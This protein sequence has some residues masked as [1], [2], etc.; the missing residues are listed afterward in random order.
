MLTWGDEHQ[1]GTHQPREALR[2]TFLVVLAEEA[3]RVAEDLYALLP[4]HWQEIARLP[5][6]GPT[7]AHNPWTEAVSV[8]DWLARWVVAHHLAGS[9]AQWIEKA[10][11]L[12]LR[13]WLDKEWQ[14]TGAGREEWMARLKADRKAPPP[15]FETHGWGSV[16]PPLRFAKAALRA[17]PTDLLPKAQLFQ[18]ADGSW[19]ELDV[20]EPPRDSEPLPGYRPA[21]FTFITPAVDQAL[22][23]P[24]DAV[25][26]EV[27]RYQEALEAH[28]ESER[29]G[30]NALGYT[31]CCWR[32]VQPDEGL[33]RLVRLQVLGLGW[34]EQARR[35]HQRSPVEYASGIRRSV[36]D[37]SRR[38]GIPLRKLPRGYPRGVAR[39]PRKQ[40]VGDLAKFLMQAPKP[41]RK[42]TRYD[43]MP[44]PCYICH[45]RDAQPYVILPTKGRVTLVAHRS[46]RHAS[47]S[48]A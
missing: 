17:F 23:D 13:R 43:R 29:A 44:S 16:S 5:T 38:L 47:R 14:G 37:L 28:L 19:E 20:P 31:E 1:A 18:T 12:T 36:I 2:E 9:E 3:P 45:V 27:Q 4:E 35:E 7:W 22:E 32:L 42:P 33:R 8:P 26:R 10:A 15:R 30:A 41:T 48:R 34:T 21:R 46:C 24:R 40:D 39:P 6:P 11:I 25:A